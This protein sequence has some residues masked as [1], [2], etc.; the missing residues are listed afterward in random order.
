MTSPAPSITFRKTIASPVGDLLLTS[1]GTAL[2]RVMFSPCTVDPAWSVAPCAVLDEAATQLGQYFAGD[3]TVFDLPIAPCGTA[4]QKVVWQALLAIPFG[5]LTSYGQLA[6]RI[7]NRNAAR[8][9][10]LAIGRNPLVVVVPCHRVIGSKG[11]LTGF[12]GGLPRK[13]ALLT[14]EC[15]PVDA[16]TCRLALVG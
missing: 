6:G 9:V 16:T 10:G 2:T 8:A 4:F 1:D 5:A 11:A 3:R 12:S 15:H 7:G 13:R 14:L